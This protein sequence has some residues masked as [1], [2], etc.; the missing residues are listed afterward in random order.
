MWTAAN[1]LGAALEDIVAEIDRGDADLATI[2]A[3]AARALE[4]DEQL[5]GEAA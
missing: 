4:Y 3:E 5:P 2:R 1:E